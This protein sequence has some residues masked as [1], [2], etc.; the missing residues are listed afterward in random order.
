MQIIRGLLLLLVASTIAPAQSYINVR[1]LLSAPDNWMSEIEESLT[2]KINAIPD[3]Q[4]VEDA[5]KAV[6]TITVD[7][8]AINNKK[9]ELMGY[10]MMALIVGNYDAKI[11]TA[12]FDGVKS[13]VKDDK[14]VDLMKYVVSGNVFLAGAL[15]THGSTDK[16]GDAYDQ[17]VG[18]LKSKALP[19]LRRFMA[20]VH[21]T[22]D[23]PKKK[24]PTT[25]Q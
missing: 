25:M 19:E 6:F 13:T 3:V 15:H 1:L 22:Y 11:M 14:A 12:F 24:I 9:D 16:I 7:V 20:M 4:V 2:T 18:K 8:N 5:D 23:K 21:E 17:I 10:S